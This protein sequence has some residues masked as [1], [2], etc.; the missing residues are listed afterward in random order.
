M[1][2]KLEALLHGMDQSTQ[3]HCIG[4]RIRYDVRF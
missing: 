1:M 2:E 3:F 4:N